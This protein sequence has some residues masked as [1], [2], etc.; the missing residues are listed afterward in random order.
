MV[1]HGG[2]LNKKSG[3]WQVSIGRCCD[4]SNKPALH[5]GMMVMGPWAEIDGAMLAG[6]KEHTRPRIISTYFDIF[7]VVPHK[8][9]VEVSKIR[10]L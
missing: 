7:P 10:N 2:A 5:C 6:M 1:G 3:E 9:V 8:A 4:L